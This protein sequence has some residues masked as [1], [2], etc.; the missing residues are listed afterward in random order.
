MTVQAQR[1]P[2]ELP[3]QLGFPNDPIIALIIAPDLIVRLPVS[4]GEKQDDLVV[5]P[6]NAIGRTGFGV[7]NVLADGVAMR[8]HG[9]IL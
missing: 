8:S 1:P 3:L 7:A 5:A 2:T 4:D 6:P 9:R